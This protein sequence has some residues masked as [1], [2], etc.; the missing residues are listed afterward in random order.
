MARANAAAH[1]KPR[2]EI[3]PGTPPHSPGDNGNFPGTH[4]DAAPPQASTSTAALSVK[5]GSYVVL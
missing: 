5:F 2:A 3:L 1:A 4:K